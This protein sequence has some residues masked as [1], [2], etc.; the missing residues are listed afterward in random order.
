MAVLV[1]LLCIPAAFPNY[2]MGPAL[3]MFD[4][5]R[6]VAY[7]LVTVAFEAWMLG[8]WLGWR[9]WASLLASLLANAFTAFA[10]QWLMPSLATWSL[11]SRLNP[12][13]FPTV[14]ILFIAFGLLSAVVEAFVWRG[15]G[16]VAHSQKALGGTIGRSV[17]THL[18]GVPLGLAILLCSPRPYIHLEETAETERRQVLAEWL[19][20][21]VLDRHQPLPSFVATAL[22]PEIMQRLGYPDSIRRAWFQKIPLI[23]VRGEKE[24]WAAAYVPNFGPFSFGEDRSHPREINPALAGKD[25]HDAADAESMPKDARVWRFEQDPA[26]LLRADDGWFGHWEVQHYWEMGK[27]GEP[28]ADVTVEPVKRTNPDPPPLLSLGPQPPIP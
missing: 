16:L 11:G 2:I 24:L 9:W 13:P 23:D 1:T 14:L 15:I 6:W 4:S 12:H 25:L 22:F 20:Q 3:E 28:V 17:V 8:R 10:P 5:R 18:M 19:R 7:V 26:W 27:N 21:K